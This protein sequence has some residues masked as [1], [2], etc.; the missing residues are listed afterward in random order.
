MRIRMP[1]LSTMTLAMLAAVVGGCAS[2]PVVLPAKAHA[3][4]T[5][6]AVRVLRE[7]PAE[8]ELLGTV[9]FEITP[10]LRWDANGN[11]NK[12]FELFRQGAAA[13]GANAVVIW[14]PADKA[15]VMAVA[16]Y[17]GKS[18][19]VP[20]RVEGEKRTAVAQAAYVVKE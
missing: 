8:Y 17:Q 19:Q 10:E 12:V 9:T 3:A 15:N 18:Y 6:D 13:T 5:P 7:R 2:E 4:T 14:A 16:G 20:I 11:A 1:A